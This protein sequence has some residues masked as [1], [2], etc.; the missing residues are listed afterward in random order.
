[1][2]YCG[3]QLSGELLQATPPMSIQVLY[4]LSCRGFDALQSRGDELIAEIIDR[5]GNDGA[6]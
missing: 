4:S 5:D 6:L 3:I 2:L 1:M